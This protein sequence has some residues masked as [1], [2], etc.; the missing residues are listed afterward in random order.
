MGGIVR[1][2]LQAIRANVPCLLQ[3]GGGDS[4]ER[5][6]RAAQWAG[7]R[8]RIIGDYD[9]TLDRTHAVVVD[10]RVF[11]VMSLKRLY[12]IGPGEIVYS[13]EEIIT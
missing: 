11:R 12:G 10:G 4:A 6:G 1:D 2:P 13:C 3:E 8:I 9:L 7:A 5:H